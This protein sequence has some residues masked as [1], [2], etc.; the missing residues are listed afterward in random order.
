MDKIIRSSKYQKALQE[1]L[2]T[3]RDGRFVVPVKAEHKSEI[4]GL[5]HDSSASGATLFVEPMG[6]VEANNQIRVLQTQE[7]AEIQR[8]L[9]ELSQTVAQ[10]AGNL[11]DNFEVVIALNLCF[12]KA[13]WPPDERPKAP[14]HRY[15]GDRPK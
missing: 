11:M 10:H 14:A 15:R 12:A 3:Q 13:S 1:N 5:V 7:K 4:P 9:Y 8:I 6:V 2:I